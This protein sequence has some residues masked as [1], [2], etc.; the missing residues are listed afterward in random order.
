VLIARRPL[1]WL[2][3]EPHA[4]LDSSGRDLLDAVLRE[5]AAAGATILMASHEMERA[6][7]LADRVVTVIGGRLSEGRTDPSRHD[8]TRGT[9][10]VG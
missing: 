4:G 9:D 7:P 1:L 6:V 5:A 10:H 3:D 2:L 8:A